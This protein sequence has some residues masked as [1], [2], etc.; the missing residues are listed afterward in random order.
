[1]AS[2]EVRK[3]YESDASP[4]HRYLLKHMTPLNPHLAKLHAASLHDEMARM[5]GAS[6]ELNFLQMLMSSIG[7][8]K[9]LDI[10]VFTGYS[11]LAAALVLPPDGKVVACDVT[12]KWVNQYGR[13]VWKEAGV[14]DKIDLRIA[15]ALDTLNA[16]LAAGEG[17][18]F[19]FAFIDADKSNYGNYYEAALQLLR[20]GGIVAVDNALWSGKVVGDEAGME[21]STLAIHRLNEKAAGDPRV[22][23]SLLNVGDGLLLCRRLK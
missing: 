2:N 14:E 22:H 9:T 12:D 8:R 13:A 19:D 3:A 17:G 23:A 4:L 15:P 18:T 7:A 16:L 6:E 5:L 10:G 21:A 20:V 11:S 1:M